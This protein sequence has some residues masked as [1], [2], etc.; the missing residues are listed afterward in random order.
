MPKWILTV[1]IAIACCGVTAAIAQSVEGL[2]IQMLEERSAEFAEDAEELLAFVRDSGEVH[3]EEAQALVDA[4]TQRMANVDVTGIGPSGGDID[5]DALVA[6]AKG[7][8]QA[9]KAAPL[10]IAFV[11]LSMPED[12]LKRTINDT[13]RAGG[14]VV[15]RGFSKEGAKPFVAAMQQLV[16][17]QGAT[18]M[19]IDPRLFRAFGVDRVPTVVAV[20][21]AFEPCDQLDCISTPPPYDVISGNVPLRY[22]LET[23]VDGGGPGA[24]VAR[25]ALTNLGGA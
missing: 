8:L 19:A 20:S 22:A 3:T 6:G 25:T 2:D 17:Q 16:D 13:T 14:I 21:S 5:L 12:S 1:G 7:N 9:P 23:F 24:P 18:N 10:L 11:S 15:F 4:G